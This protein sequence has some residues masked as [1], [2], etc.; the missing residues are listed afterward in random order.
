MKTL[1][2][3]A[4]V[5]LA[6]C[7]SACALFASS[8]AAVDIYRTR[9]AATR[10]ATRAA[11]RYVVRDA[12]GYAATAPTAAAATPFRMQATAL[13][14]YLLYG[15]DATMP[16]VGLLGTVAPTSTPG[17]SADWTRRSTAGTGFTLTASTT[18]AGPR[19]R[20]R[21]RLVQVATDSRPAGVR[22]R[23][24]AAPTFPEVQVNV[25]GTPFKG[26]S[27]TA[28]VRGFIDDHIHIG[29]FEFLGGRFH[30]GRPWSPY[31]V[32]VALQD[33]PDHQPER[34]RRRGRELLRL[35]QPGG[36]PRAP[37]GWPTSPAGRATSR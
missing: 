16:A 34:R 20:P 37:H 7:A 9:T 14:R 32:T 19:R 4:V 33:C 36:H 5:T 12:L 28:P 10:C 21:G 31:G 18:G 2:A 30:C 6:A 11:G 1:A 27:P 35:R 3:R 8:A 22:A 24:R 15:P 29:A 17:P 26:A 13:G 25:T 23:R